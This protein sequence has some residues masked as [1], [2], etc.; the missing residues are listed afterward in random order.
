MDAIMC[1]WFD[2]WMDTA[3]RM[4]YWPFFVAGNADNVQDICGLWQK[5]R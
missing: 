3:L 2:I 4:Y 5:N 1:W